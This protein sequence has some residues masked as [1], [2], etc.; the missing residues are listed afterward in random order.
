M[1]WDDGLQN[2]FV[3]IGQQG[4]GMRVLTPK[5]RLY[6]DDLALAGEWVVVITLDGKAVSCDLDG[7]IKAQKQSEARLAKLIG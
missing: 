3:I 1:A 5:S 6:V 7:N 4:V 2:V